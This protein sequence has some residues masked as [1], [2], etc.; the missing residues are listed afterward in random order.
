MV[1]FRCFTTIPCEFLRCKANTERNIDK[2]LP[3][4][5]GNVQISQSPIVKILL[6]SRKFKC[7]DY[8]NVRLSRIAPIRDGTEKRFS[9]AGVQ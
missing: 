8:V 9:P 4:S 5:K 1:Q 6:I 2:P 3:R 7:Y